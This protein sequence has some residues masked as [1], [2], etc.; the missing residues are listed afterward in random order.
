MRSGGVCARAIQYVFGGGMA[1]AFEYRNAVFGKWCGL[2]ERKSVMTL[3]D[4]IL[5]KHGSGAKQQLVIRV[6][7]SD[8]QRE[9]LE[10]LFRL[11]GKVDM[12]VGG[13]QPGR[14]RLA[15]DRIV[16]LERN[17]IRRSVYDRLLNGAI[18]FIVS[19]A[20]AMHNHF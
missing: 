11:E 3:E 16:A 18:A 19:L 20:I 2:A 15:E 7:D 14:M 17:D 4:E 1:E 10:K 12:L 9:V 5:G 13:Q 8:F 6:T